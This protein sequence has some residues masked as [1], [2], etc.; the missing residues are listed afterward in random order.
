MNGELAPVLWALVIFQV[1]HF[2][3]DFVLAPRHGLRG[4]ERYLLAGRGVHAL[5]HSVGSFPAIL[6]LAGFDVLLAVFFV[7]ELVLVYHLLWVRNWLGARDE[8]AMVALTGA[9]QLVHQLSY[10]AVVALVVRPLV[11]V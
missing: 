3:A 8:S 7:A 1:K 11:I 2:L 4:G 6:L 9:E 5:L 10:L